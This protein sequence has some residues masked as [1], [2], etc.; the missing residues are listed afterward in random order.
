LE[1]PSDE[2][3]FDHPGLDAGAY[4]Y[5]IAAA[6]RTTA[7]SAG[8]PVRQG[9]N[10][11]VFILTQDGQGQ[12][13]VGGRAFTASAGSLAWLDTARAYAHGCHRTS[14]RWRYM[15]V[16]VVG[17]GLDVLHERF[18]AEANPVLMVSGSRRLDA[19]FAGVLDLMAARP[20][21][22]AAAANAAVSR[23]LEHIAELR[24]SGERQGQGGRAGPEGLVDAIRSDLARAWT[25]AD[26]TALSGVSR[27]Q[28]HRMFLR[29][30]GQ[31]PMVWLRSERLL[32]AKHLLVGGKTRILEIAARC[33]YP[34]PYH[35]SR[36]FSRVT[37]ISPSQFRKSGGV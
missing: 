8:E 19:E 10:Q 22:L 12:I 7:L 14:E 27:A 25:I 11:H 29:Q 21:F 35:F 1:L 37:G 2:I 13:D 24:L 4:P 28:L 30:F 18:G 9:F 26:M 6:G 36:E 16:A 33:G 15:W 3:L 5:R 34:D 20:A 31:P 23:I 17:Y 32:L